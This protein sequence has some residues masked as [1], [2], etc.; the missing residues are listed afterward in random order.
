M[1]GQIVLQSRAFPTMILFFE[2][3]Q[4]SPRQWLCGSRRSGVR[5]QGVPSAMQRLIV[6]Q[7]LQQCL[8]HDLAKL[9][10]CTSIAH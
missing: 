1:L 7:V 3:R 8:M 9:D 4:Q 5:H 10:R 2:L 6:A